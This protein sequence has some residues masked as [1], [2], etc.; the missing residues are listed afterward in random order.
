MILQICEEEYSLN[1]FAFE[2]R[3]A[4]DDT[5]FH[6][7]VSCQFIDALD[8]TDLMDKLRASFGGSFVVIYND[9][10][11]P[12]EGYVFDDLRFHIDGYREERTL[13]LLKVVE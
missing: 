11:Y 5:T 13:S 10:E 7:T 1:D 3:K 2:I 6:Y 4:D 12:F 9:T 8:I